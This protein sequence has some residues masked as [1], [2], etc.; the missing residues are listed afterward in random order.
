MLDVCGKQGAPAV[1]RLQ[2]CAGPGLYQ[3]PAA[4][5]HGR[6]RQGESQGMNVLTGSFAP[7]VTLQY[8]YERGQ[9]LG[10]NHGLAGHS[11]LLS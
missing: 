7:P 11:P 3:A 5:P 10:E 1:P 2:G 4:H 8:V 6:Q 9:I